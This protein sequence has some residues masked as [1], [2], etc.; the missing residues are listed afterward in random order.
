MAEMN[1][2]EAQEPRHF[3]MK[4]M[5]KWAYFL[6]IMQIVSGGYVCLVA[7]GLLVGSF[8]GFAPG[9]FFPLFLMFL[10]F[11]G[12]GGV[13]LWLGISILKASFRAIDYA[14]SNDGKDLVA[15][16]EKLGDMSLAWGILTIGAIGAIV[17]GLI[18][19]VVMSAALGSAFY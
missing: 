11:G 5:P 13:I 4:A 19:L 2:S 6:A 17:I 10:I 3:K 16:H 1:V 15:Y 8:I 12:I 9:A 7:L 14:A 18:A